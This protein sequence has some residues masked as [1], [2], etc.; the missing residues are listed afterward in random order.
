[1][2]YSVSYKG[3]KVVR[4]HA[5]KVHSGSIGITVAVY[6]G[7]WSTSRPDSFTPGNESRY[8]SNRRTG[9][10]GGGAQTGWKL[11]RI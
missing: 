10:G 1:M 4:V 8:P 5:M 7:E 2:V 9:G 11:W 3:K 6:G